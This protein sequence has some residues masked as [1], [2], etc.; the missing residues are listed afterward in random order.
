MSENF[1]FFLV[2]DTH[3]FENTLGIEGKAYQ[4]RSATDQKCIAETGAIL[5]SVFKEL[6]SLKEIDTIIIPGDLIF[7]GEK[8]SHKGFIKK[9]EKLKKSGKKIFVLT[10]RHDYGDNAYAFDGDRRISVESTDKEELVDLYWD[11]GFGQ[12]IAFDERTLSYVAQLSDDIRLIALNSD[13]DESGFRGFD[14]ELLLWAEKQIKAANNSGNYIFAIS[15]YPI[16]PA[17]PIME[18]IKDAKVSNWN[19]TANRLANMGINLIFTG[20]MHLQ[21]IEAII[22]DKGNILYDVSTGCI[23]GCPAAYRTVTFLF[24]GSIDIKSSFVKAFDWDKNGM[25]GQE[26]FK[27]KFNL[28]IEGVIDDMVNDFDRIVGMT[29]MKKTK[30]NEK[31]FKVL[32]SILKKITLGKLGRI[33]FFK[34]EEQYKNVLLKDF[35]LN[36]TRQIFEGDEP[37]SQYTPED[38]MI[39]CFLKR[40]WPIIKT[41]EIKFGKKNP[42]L[43]DIKAFVASA[44]YNDGIPDNDYILP[45]KWSSNYVKCKQ[46]QNIKIL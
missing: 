12:S 28:M 19:K 44:I 13:G 3:Y 17:S 23:V 10:A 41:L 39:M 18:F 31:A 36:I 30:A 1:S 5:N 40:L 4:Q 37:Y 29:G 35:A 22:S 6:E 26:Y 24:D 32:G 38:K 16:I 34:V 27:W 33:M 8:A 21:S 42:R 15:H 2:T 9:L 11:Y 25:T 7:N 14:E 45:V 46:V 20:H 43:K